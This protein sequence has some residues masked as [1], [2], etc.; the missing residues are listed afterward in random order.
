MIPKTRVQKSSLP[1][2]GKAK[3]KERM[4][5]KRKTNV[6]NATGRSGGSATACAYLQTLCEAAKGITP[7]NRIAITISGGYALAGVEGIEPSL[8]VLETS[9]MPFDHTPVFVGATPTNMI[10]TKK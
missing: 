5:S 1:G 8:K 4:Q 10:I 6:L 9:V 2:S 7:G 3:A